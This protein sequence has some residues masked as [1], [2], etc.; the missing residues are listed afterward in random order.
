MKSKF[1]LYLKNVPSVKNILLV[2]FIRVTKYL[3]KYDPLSLRCTL[4]LLSYGDHL[5][6]D[7]CECDVNG[8]A[9]YIDLKY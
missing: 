5:L 3:V 9:F 6:V 4:F 2:H 8:M 1:T 7:R